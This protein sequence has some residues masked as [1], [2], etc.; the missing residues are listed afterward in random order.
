MIL[1]GRMLNHNPSVCAMLGELD[2]R[3]V[4]QTGVEEIITR[5]AASG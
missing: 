3:S 2:A 5:G 1:I 4:G